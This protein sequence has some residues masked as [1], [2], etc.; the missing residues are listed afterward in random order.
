[1]WTDERINDEPDYGP[2]SRHALLAVMR[3]KIGDGLQVRY[4]APQDLPQELR[5][6][7]AKLDG[8]RL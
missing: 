4:E 6:L 3:R 8:K 7:V 2:P 1:M 5:E